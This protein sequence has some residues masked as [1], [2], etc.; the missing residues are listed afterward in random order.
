MLSTKNLTILFTVLLSSH[1]AY[2]TDCLRSICVG[3]NALTTDNEVVA[4]TAIKGEKVV[5]QQGYYSLE[6]SPE[7]LSKQVPRYQDLEAGTTVLNSSNDIGVV[8]M[9]FENGKAQY[10]VGY[11]SYVSSDLSPEIEQLGTLKQGTVVINPSDEMGKVLKVFKNNQVQYNIGY[12]NYII[13]RSS[14]SEEVSRFGDFRKDIT[15]ITPSE[16]IGKVQN[17][18]ADGRIRYTSGYY[19]YTNKA[20]ELSVEVKAIGPLSTNTLVMNQGNDIGTVLLLFK[21]E[22][23][24]YQSGYYT[25]IDK[26]N[27]LSPQV[28]VIGDIRVGQTIIDSADR[29]GT[30]KNLF[31]DGRIQY[32]SGYYTFV[33]KN[34]VP[35]VDKLGDWRSDA[36]AINQTN[37]VGHV[38]RMFKDG[39]IEFLAGYYTTIEKD[40]DLSAEVE[41]HPTYEKNKWYGTDSFRAGKIVHA[42]QNGKV[43]VQTTEDQLF[44]YT[45]LY[46][47]T[48]DLL[49]LKADSEVAEVQFKKAKVIAVFEN[50]TVLYEYKIRIKTDNPDE[51][52]EKLVKSSAK[53]FGTKGQI[54]SNE[55]TKLD[56][57]AWLL[58][59][60]K[61]LAFSDVNIHSHLAFLDAAPMVINFEKTAETK[62]ML[63]Q[64]LSKN[65]KLISDSAVRK[66]VMQFLGKNTPDDNGDTNGPVVDNGEGYVVRVNNPNYLPEVEKLLQAK[67]IA[68]TLVDILTRNPSMDIEIQENKGL[69]STAC[70]MKY[71]LTANDYSFR[72]SRAKK[73]FSLFKKKNPCRNA[74]RKFLESIAHDV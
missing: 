54:L 36:L 29:I 31:A 28:S 20:E 13:A 46:P 49:G 72:A 57:E 23:V 48:S 43:Q 66:K 63:I 5:Y 56:T 6:I 42:F 58:S 33:E 38:K 74:F 59:L 1:L 55:Q 10:K 64:Y 65:P 30:T 41:D 68:Y 37:Q 73:V 14:L 67:K 51:I 50:G 18:F 22:K 15:V 24:Q 61:I 44:V 27:N 25:H 26:A 17:I 3:M 62:E 70:V 19:T 16:T 39:R 11:Y 21:N 40:Q 4:V 12:Y 7:N 71:K 8:Q 34:L 69:V 2:A 52:K 53:L 35:E 47:E 9:V 60:A 32:N 45:Q